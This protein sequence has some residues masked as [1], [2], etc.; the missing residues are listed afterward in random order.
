MATFVLVHAAGGSTWDWHRLVPELRALGHDAVTMDLP[1]EDEDATLAG[2]AAAVVDAVD[3]AGARGGDLAVVGHSLG[4]IT[5]A[6]VAGELDAGLLVFVT[7]MVPAPGETISDWWAN[8]RHE[9]AD[10]DDDEVTAY[11]DDVEP[12][13]AAEALRRSRGQTMGGMHEPWPLPALPAVPTRAVVCTLD[14][15]FPPDFMRRV[16]AERLG[17]AAGEP[18]ELVAGHCPALSRPAELA[19]LLDRCWAG[20]HRQGGDADVREP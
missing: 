4:G 18:L 5:A 9:Q 11:L 19:A 16:L 10:P 20:R 3:A 12:A 7:A 8:T 6:L 13:L 15:F 2:Y 17:D 1:C 14:R